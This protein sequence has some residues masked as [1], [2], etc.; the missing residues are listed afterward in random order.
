MLPLLVLAAALDDTPARTVALLE[1]CDDPQRVVAQ[2]A[3]SDRVQVHSALAGAGQTCYSVTLMS[4]R[5]PVHGYVLGDGLG[6]IAA[7]V[8]QRS[9]SASVDPAPPALARAPT[10]EQA[11]S[12]PA[13]PRYFEDLDAPDVYDRPLHLA[14]VKGNYILVHFWSSRGKASRGDLSLVQNLLDTYGKRGLAVV[15]I[16]LDQDRAKVAEF[17]EDGGILWPVYL[18]RRGVARR[19]GVSPEALPASILLNGRREIIGSNL[20]GQELRKTVASLFGR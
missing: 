12:A 7:F 3:P 20:R 5:T 16:S 9:A 4:S 1:T 6:A 18:D 11:K 8:R 2:I 17:M 15:G 10:Q 19:Y 13:A 14:T